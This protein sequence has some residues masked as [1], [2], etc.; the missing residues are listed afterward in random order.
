MLPSH[1]HS[2]AGCILVAALCP[3]ASEPSACACCEGRVSAPVEGSLVGG[4][5]SPCGSDA[6]LVCRGAA[7]AR[8][9]RVSVVPAGLS[10]QSG[11][12]GG[13]AR[14]GALQQQRDIVTHQWLLDVTT[15]CLVSSLN[16]LSFSCVTSPRRQSGDFAG[17]RMLS[18]WG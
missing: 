10:L 9:S 8:D 11:V 1:K 7:R 17:V 16:R 5:H 13:G 3:G 15:C 6:S 14:G 4:V 18:V 12:C 2:S